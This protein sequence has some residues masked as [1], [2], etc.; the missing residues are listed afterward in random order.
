MNLANLTNNG[1]KKAPQGAKKLNSSFSLLNYIEKHFAINQGSQVTYGA[2]EYV[3]G[4]ST[5]V[6][7]N[8]FER[9]ADA[10]RKCIE[11]K[12]SFNIREREYRWD[13]RDR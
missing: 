6:Y 13:E 9:N 11:L 2:G 8:K 10:R 3:E 1:L 12:F 7:V 5:R 4:L